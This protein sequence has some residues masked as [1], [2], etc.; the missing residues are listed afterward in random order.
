[1]ATTR[2]IPRPEWESFLEEVTEME[3]DHPVRL[4]S[5]PSE[6]GGQ[7]LSGA[8]LIG[9]SLEEKGSEAGALDLTVKVGSPQG[10]YTH[11]IEHARTIYSLEDDAGH[12]ECL[13][14]ESEGDQKTRVY[15]D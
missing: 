15:F 4:E 5:E 1:M 11:H 8:P 3:L 10:D 2:E 7:V 14:I 6:G 12:V 13:D 9:L